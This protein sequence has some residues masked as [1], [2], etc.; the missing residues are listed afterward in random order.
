MWWSC[1]L[2]QNLELIQQLKEITGAKIF[3]S[4]RQ[5]NR[6]NTEIY[7]DDLT[8]LDLSVVID[9]ETLRSWQ[10]SLK[11]LI[12]GSGDDRIVGGRNND[13]IQGLGGDDELEG[14]DE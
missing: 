14:G 4:K 10:G 7:S 8:W 11:D 6:E 1:E 9:H 13:T 12:G 3:S 5:L 2:G